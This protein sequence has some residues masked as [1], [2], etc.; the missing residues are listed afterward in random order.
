M[1]S[2]LI[3][4]RRRSVFPPI[5]YRIRSAPERRSHLPFWSHPLFARVFVRIDSITVVHSSGIIAKGITSQTL[6]GNAAAFSL[7]YSGTVPGMDSINLRILFHSV[8]WGF[9][10]HVDVGVIANSTSAPAELVSTDSL[11]FGDVL[12]DTIGRRSLRITNTGCS[13]LRVD[14]VVSSNPAIFSLPPLSFP[15]TIQGDSTVNIPV[16][17]SPQR[18]GP[19]IES[20]ELGTNAGHRFIELEGQGLSLAT[21]SDSEQG[22]TD[23]SIVPNPA[24][25]IVSV[26]GITEDSKYEIIDLLGR[27]VLNGFM[28]GQTISVAALP[29]GIY[30]L[31]CA[32]Q[33]ARIVISRK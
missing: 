5:P 31:R 1:A 8:E 23:F 11:Q 32:E 30:V 13:A 2:F 4:L 12:V 18:V 14:S 17:F 33:T 24:S 22:A 15:F 3:R 19:S 28:D 20:I 10:E 6:F 21:V 26:R 16:T 7:S 25:A 29:E 27:T 9:K